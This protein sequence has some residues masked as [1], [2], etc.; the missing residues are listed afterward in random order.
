MATRNLL[1]AALQDPLNEWYATLLPRA[2]SMPTHS[3]PLCARFCLMS[4]SCIPLLSFGRW[5]RI[6]LA[7]SRSIYNACPMAEPKEMEGDTR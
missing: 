5:R 3:Y 4:E 6:L 1:S 2:A 7:N